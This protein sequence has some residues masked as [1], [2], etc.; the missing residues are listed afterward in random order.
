MSGKNIFLI[1]LAVIAVGGIAFLTIQE[2]QKPKGKAQLVL[3]LKKGDHHEYKI[4]HI[5][6]TIQTYRDQMFKLDTMANISMAFDVISVDSNGTMN[7]H[8]YY[9]AIAIDA[10]TGSQHIVYD[11]SKP[12]VETNDIFLTAIAD[13]YSTVL[14]NKFA[15]KVSQAGEKGEIVGFERVQSLMKEKIRKDAMKEVNDA[16]MSESDKEV[17][18]K[19][20]KGMMEMA[21]KQRTAFYNSIFASVVND[22][23]EMID[24][25]FIKYPSWQ[26]SSGSKWYDKTQFNFGIVVDAN[27]TYIFKRKENGTAYIDV[28]SDVDMGKKYK[29]AEIT[30]RETVK[31]S[32]SGVRSATNAVDE[33]TGLLQ[34]SEAIIKFSGKQHIETEKTILPLR[35]NMDIPIRIEGSTIIEL[36][37]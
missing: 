24:S 11:S 16:N 35:P 2:K 34:K 6:E 32:I 8:F 19:L 21:I 9:K 27:N 31:K 36:I 15:V 5:Q 28:I 30:Q 4:S 37:K 29:I 12:V 33:A 25:L 26:V 7:L 23:K 20:I 18:T 3:Q 14:K 17:F 1:V 10:N 22:T 13:I